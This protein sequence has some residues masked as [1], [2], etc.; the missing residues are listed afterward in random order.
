MVYFLERCSEFVLYCLGSICPS[1]TEHTFTGS[2]FV[3][4]LSGVENPHRSIETPR[5]ILE[6][7]AT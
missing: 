1:L 2:V 7:C 4:V 6:H 3:R 5:P